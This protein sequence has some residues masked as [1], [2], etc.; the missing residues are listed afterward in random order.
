MSKPS[1]G[2]IACL[3]AG[4]L[5]CGARTGLTTPDIPPR[6]VVICPMSCT[7]HVVSQRTTG[8][9][10]N[11]QPGDRCVDNTAFD[12]T[13]GPGVM[14]N[15]N[16]CAPDDADDAT[17]IAQCKTFFQTNPTGLEGAFISVTSPGDTPDPGRPGLDCDGCSLPVATMMACTQQAGGVVHH[18]TSCGRITVT[19]SGH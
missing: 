3:A 19:V 11:H 16:A 7:G 13:S 10:C 2:L 15:G 9:V 6:A 17:A 5:G 8:L 18:G 14:L 12:N 1:I 4:T